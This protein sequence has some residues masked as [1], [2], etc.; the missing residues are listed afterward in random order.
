VLL[1]FKQT[2]KTLL[3]SNAVSLKG[4]LTP[5]SLTPTNVTVTPEMSLDH[6]RIKSRVQGFN[7]PSTIGYSMQKKLP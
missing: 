6:N 1:T 2:N 4:I 5:M 3:L 7:F